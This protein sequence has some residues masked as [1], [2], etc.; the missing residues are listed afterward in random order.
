MRYA[1]KLMLVGLVSIVAS[2]VPLEV[3]AHGPDSPSERLA[4]IGP[5]PGFTLTTQNGTAFSMFD[6]RGKVVV[7]NF[8]FTRCTD[9]CP[10]AT[11]KMVGIQDALGEQFSRDVFFVSVTVDPAHDTPEV[12]LD[13]A[14][15]LGSD[16]SGWAYLTGSPAT[17]RD[18]ARKYGVFHRRHSDGEVEHNLLTSLVDRGGT[19]RVQYMSERFDPGELLHDIRDLIAEDG[20]Q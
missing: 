6:L 9:A 8:V 5:A 7:L 1:L 12:L 4:K 15:S 20:V 18:V 17:I 14:R 13:Y 11:Y 10:L 3:S 2:L 16:L 19:L